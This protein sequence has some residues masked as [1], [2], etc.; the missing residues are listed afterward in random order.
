MQEFPDSGFYFGRCEEFVAKKRTTA[1]KC[2]LSFTWRRNKSSLCHTQKICCILL[3]LKKK[4]FG[5]CTLTMKIHMQI[6]KHTNICSDKKIKKDK[7]NVP[8]ARGHHLHSV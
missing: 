7:Y 8:V 1:Q 3:I 5:Q 2:L 6:H 4:R